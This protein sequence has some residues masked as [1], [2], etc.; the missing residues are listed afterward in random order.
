MKAGAKHGYDR[1]FVA[2]F[3]RAAAR[4]ISTRALAQLLDADS[5]E[6]NFGTLH[7]HGYHAIGTQHKLA[8]NCIKQWN[9]DVPAYA[10]TGG[11]NADV[12][13]VQEYTPATT[14]ADEL[15]ADM[16]LNR[17]LMIPR[18]RWRVATQAFASRWEAW[19]QANGYIDYTDM[20]EIP[21][22]DVDRAPGAPS[23]GIL[24]EAQDASPLQMALFRKWG[25]EMGF[26]VLGG[27][28]DQT[29]FDWAGARPEVMVSGDYAG[30][31]VLEQSYRVPRAVH[32]LAVKTISTVRVRADAPYKPR[33]AEGEVRRLNGI[34]L[35]TPELIVRDMRRYLDEDKS[36][37][38]LAS[39]SYMLDPLIRALRAEG[40][41]F[42]NPYRVKAGAW[43]PLRG[44]S[45]HGTSS[46]ERLLNFRE[47]V[48][49]ASTAHFDAKKMLSWYEIIKATGNVPRGKR[50]ELI[51]RLDALAHGTEP[52]EMD[53]SIF[54]DGATGTVLVESWS[55]LGLPAADIFNFFEPD[56]QLL[57]YL[58]RPDLE[59][60]AVRWLIDNAIA[61]KS[62]ALEYPARVLEKSG[63]AALE[64]APRVIVGTIHSV[65][66][67]EADCVYVSPDVS[68][69]G[70]VAAAT[71][72]DA[73]DSLTRL[74]YVAYT[75]ARESLI[76][77]DA[78]SKFTM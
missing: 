22:R 25:A 16:M 69:A 41:A 53:A 66:G 40:I 15:Y 5:E 33:D 11:R 77:L 63:I 39:C 18:E 71:T 42:H 70:Y 12:D 67:G 60:D 76:L 54:E 56:C 21:L 32:E 78:G 10:L 58:A 68:Y 61:A 24:D 23:V 73:Q 17:D 36:I 26:I 57:R 27:D 1:V 43:N 48:P 35:Q 13:D 74:K 28:P 45:E 29:I 47:Q 9:A 34:S 38:L 55:P 72:R 7:A 64:A 3:T 30:K 4:E 44:G 19:K 31:R 2:S 75:R 59:R 65:K 52:Q 6:P 14:S 8:E 51:A 50:A 62:K 49:L 37:M 20:L 46:I